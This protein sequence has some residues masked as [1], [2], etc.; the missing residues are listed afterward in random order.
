M[1]FNVPETD[2]KRVVIVGGGFGGL[3]LANK[4]ETSNFQVVL[5]DRNNYHQFLPLI[6]QVAS[7]GLEPSSISFPFRKIFQKRR[8]F[9][10]RWAEVTGVDSKNNVI[11]TS[12]GDLRYDYLVIA[13]GTETNYFGNANIENSAISMKTVEEA[14]TLRNILLSNLEKSLTCEDIKEKQ[15]LMNIVIVG[16]GATGVEISGVLSEMKRFI[17]PKD[18]PDMD[19]HKVNVYLIE[20]SKKLLGAMSPQSSANSEKFLRE[21]GVNVML[22]TKVLD[23][24][25]GKVI[26]DNGIEIPT[27]TFVWVSGVKAATFDNIDPAVLGRGSRIMVDEFNRVKGLDNVFA[28]GD[29]CLQTEENYPYGHPQLAQVAIQQGDLLSSNLKR[30]EKNK[31]PVPFHYRNFGSLATVGRNKAVADLK[32][33]KMNGWFAWIIWLVIHLR[34]ILGIRNKVVV[35]I[36]WIWNYITYDQSIRLIMAAKRVKRPNKC[37]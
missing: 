29:I 13:A 37:C 5:V 33:I 19:I 27:R 9:Y 26:L 15:A 35:L 20:A 8:N 31:Q 21:M 22:D 24:K 12:I 28:I 6:Y 11:E 23:Y 30:I 3:K 16:G 25:D 14:L 18:Y 7:A 17:I 34:S 32:S 10:F 1:G 2:K 4:L 36:N